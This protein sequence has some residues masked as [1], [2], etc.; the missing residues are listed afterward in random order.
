MPQPRHEGNGQT[1]DANYQATLRTGGTTVSCHNTPICNISLAAERML[2]FA[3]NFLGDNLMMRVCLS[4][5]S[6]LLF[7]NYQMFAPANVG[8]S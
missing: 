1:Q 8:F 2:W 4:C 6:Y 7:L 5:C 3:P